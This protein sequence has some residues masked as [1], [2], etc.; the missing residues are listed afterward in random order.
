MIGGRVRDTLL[1][2]KISAATASDGFS[3]ALQAKSDFA[4]VAASALGGATPVADAQHAAAPVVDDSRVNAPAAGPTGLAALAPGIGPMLTPVSA[5]VAIA[6][7]AVPL[8]DDLAAALQ[9]DGARFPGY[10]RGDAI[11]QF[12]TH[13]LNAQVAAFLGGAHTS[14]AAPPVHPTPADGIAGGDPSGQLWF[15]VDDLNNTGLDHV[16]SDG[17]G[18]DAADRPTNHNVFSNVGLDSASGLYFAFNRDNTLRDGHITNDQESGQASEI[19]QIDQVFGTGVDAD[20]VN[21]LAVDPINHIVFLGLFGQSDQ[22][23]GILEITYNPATGAM[24]SPYNG[25][26]GVVTD[27]NHMLFHDDNNGHVNGS[28][29]SSTNIVAMQ[30]DLQNGNLYFVDQSNGHSFAFGS[31][32]NWNATNGVYVV[33]TTGSVGGGTAPTPTQLSLNSQF[34]AGDNNN[35]IEGVALNE[36]QGIIYLAVNNASNSTSK[37]FWMPIAGGTATQMSMPG[38]VTLGFADDQGSGVN[39]I[40]FDPN[41]RQLYVSDNSDSQLVQLTLSA[42]GHTFTGGNSDFLT[43]DHSVGGSGPTGLYFDPLPTL[44]G[45]THTLSGTATE[46]VQGGSAL[47]LLTAAPTITD[48]QDGASNKLHMGFAKIQVINAQTGDQLFISGQ[49][50]GTVDSGKIAVSWNSSTHTLTLTGNETESE[51]ATLMSQISFQD[52]GTDN[53]TGSHPTRTLDW[54]VSD[55][56]TVANPTTS[57]LNDA[58]TT[59]TIDRAPTLVADGYAVLESATS[60]GTSG[61][62]GT[63]VFGNDSDKDGDA[64]TVTAVNGSG[65]NVSASAAGTY[66]HLTLNANGSFSYLA[67]STAAIDGAANGSH[68]VDTFTYTAS[69]GLGGVTTQNVGF[70]IDRAPTVAADAGTS[71]ES[72]SGSGN[73]LTNDSDKDGDSLTVS[74][75]NGVGGNIG[76]S[77][78]GTY[79]HLTLNANGAYSYL[80]DNTAA[81]NG[82]ATG[83]HLTDTFSYTAN[84]GHGGTTTANLVVT[85][86]RPPTMAADANGVVRSATATT[87]AG[88]GVLVN[89]SDR[90]GDSLTVSAVA[91]SAGNVGAAIAG[92]YGH[93]TLNANGS[94]SYVADLTAA[95]DGAANGSHPL[96]T[97]AY[98]ASD[99]HGGTTNSTLVFT[100]DRPPTVAADSY[101]TLESGSSSG[102][103]GTGG[104]G[105]LGNDSDKD[106]DA[107]TVTA[108]NGSGGNVGTSVAGTYGHLTLNANGSFSYLAD[109][110]AAIDGAAN[111]SHP[112]DTFTYT[113]S[114]GLGGV[115][116]QNVSFTIDRAPTVVADAGTS[117]ESSSGSGN[118]LTN[119]SDKDGD[120]LTVSAVAGLAGNVGSSVAGTYGHLTLNANGSYSY[121]ANNTAAIDGAAT[122]SHLTD[123]FSYTASDGHGGTTT[124]NL[125]MTLDRAP[126]VVSD[127]ANVAESATAS[128]IAG[129]GVLVNDNDRDGDS[130]TV[131]AV[132][133]L[134][135]NVGASTAGTYGHLTLNADGSYSYVADLTA[136]INAAAQGSHPLDTFAY[137]ASDGHGGTTSSSLSFAIDRPAIAGNDAFTT[138]QATAIGTGL[139]LFNNNGSGADHDPDGSG[140]FSV[141]GVTGGTVGT[142]FALPS[143]ALLTVHA[144]GTFA[145]D[146]NHAFD[147]LHLAAPGSGAANTSTTDTF[148]Y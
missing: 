122:G 138:D 15:G 111:G 22:Y 65:G 27:F 143:G 108:V 92:T 132:A 38:G 91:G 83:S 103:A 86:D 31:G 17:T 48:P 97:F 12:G 142:P 134:A 68:P 54:T 50:S 44:N 56:I 14:D 10:A 141:T 39:P 23:T 77:V 55:G 37:L 148:S 71:V 82:A 59:L 131:S 60:T 29:V 78:A 76:V 118:V 41:N 74:A 80:A 100:I 133:G 106:G 1:D 121:L 52:T 114:D 75:V 51:Y 69:D 18:H 26:T 53:S 47:T 95:I 42:D 84:D 94:Y 13:S 109:N 3:F 5:P 127:S 85:L 20:E 88:A 146:P 136:A 117:V 8:P 79:G 32:T 119:D 33:S 30:Y 145:Y 96:D 7:L 89:D 34:A 102:T 49:Q 19:Q 126:T 61:T 40:A 58:R 90:D 112:L 105:V 46:A 98:T 87:T 124:T 4:L 67:D 21:A 137:T 28:S 115:S 104:T 110:T 113:V 73:L 125:V 6:P 130:L 72:S 25:T 11:P 16:D 9:S 120:S 66:G 45:G 35:Y 135:G 62:G 107:F 24:T 101:A 64:F 57:D 129:S 81:I 144:D 123:T 128:A 93:L 140:V 63:G 147:S 70:T 99:G 2:G 43:I 36:A 116:T 139:N